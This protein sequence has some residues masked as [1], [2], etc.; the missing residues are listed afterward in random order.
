M[1]MR[2]PVF[3]TVARCERDIKQLSTAIDA[4]LDVIRSSSGVAADCDALVRLQERRHSI[5]CA[6]ADYMDRHS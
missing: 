5:E 1:V 6:L 2:D 3:D 4:L